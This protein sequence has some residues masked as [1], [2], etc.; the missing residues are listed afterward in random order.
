[1]IKSYYVKPQ[2]LQVPTLHCSPAQ[3]LP[4]GSGHMGGAVNL[5][6]YVFGRQVLERLLKVV[7]EDNS[8]Q[9]L[10]R[11]PF[12]QQTQGAIKCK[13]AAPLLLCYGQEC[14][15]PQHIHLMFLP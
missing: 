7:A 11:L 4:G 10:Y 1:M 3:G 15:Y 8:F 13:G 6:H 5:Q 2:H 14:G 12:M 9:H